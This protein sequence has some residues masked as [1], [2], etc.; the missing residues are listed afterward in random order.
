MHKITPHFFPTNLLKLAES[1]SY[2]IWN[3][4]IVLVVLVMKLPL[5]T[6]AEVP[7]QLLVKVYFFPPLLFIYSFIYSSIYSFIYSIIYSFIYLFIHLFIRS[8]IHS[9]SH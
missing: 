7:V 4:V 9:F 1:K 8:F 6:S 3:L 5:T 2:F